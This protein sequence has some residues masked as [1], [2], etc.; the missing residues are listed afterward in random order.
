MKSLLINEQLVKK[1]IKYCS[2]GTLNTL[3][4]ITVMS[5]LASLGVHYVVYTA[6]GYCCAFLVSFFLNLR[7]TFKVNGQIG[8]RLTK[9]IFINVVNLLQ[10][11]LIQIF[12]IEYAKQPHLVAI[13][14][15]MFWYVV[16]GFLMNQRFVY[17]T[18]IKY[19]S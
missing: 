13:L 8:K 16:F 5:L 15:G 7:F 12:L 14:A 18:E 9:F 4:N 11:E 2:V 19:A 17:R 1:I 10:V 3:V 6:V